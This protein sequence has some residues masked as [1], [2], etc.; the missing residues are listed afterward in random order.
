MIPTIDFLAIDPFD[1]DDPLLTVDLDNLALAT[2][3]GTT[4]DHH[5]IVLADG[6]RAGLANSITKGRSISM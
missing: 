1:V 6:Y 2:L 4:D 3:V 5:F